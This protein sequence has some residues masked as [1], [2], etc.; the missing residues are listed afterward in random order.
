[1]QPSPTGNSTPLLPAEWAPQAFVQLTWPDITTD[2]AP[3]LSEAEDC[4]CRMA[5]EISRR[6]PLLIVCRNPRQVRQSLQRHHVSAG[7]GIHFITCP[8]NDTWARDHAFITTLHPAVVLHDFRF[9][10]WGG[11]Y[12]SALD[13]AINRRIFSRLRRLYRQCLP[14]SPSTDSFLLDEQDLVLEGGSIDTDGQGTV[15]T[16]TS[17]LLSPGR[18]PSLEQTDITAELKRILHARRVL[19]LRHGHLE[20]DDTDGHID[21]LARFCSPDTIAYAQCTD[22]QD[23]QAADL[24]LMEAELRA[25]RTADGRPYTLVPLPLPAPIHDEDGQRLPATYANF[26]IINGAVLCPTYGQPTADALAIRRLR[27]AFPTREVIGIDCRVLIRQHGSLHCST[28]QYP[29]PV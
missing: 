15:L 4:Y 2:W 22:S 10:G 3:Y 18:N 17:C 6:Q 13:D 16:T 27:T 26:L 28:M 8:I 24:G 25:L 21:T 5:D 7:Q 20:G 1:M 12:E 11:K 14:G 23:P 19:W 29:L 9:N